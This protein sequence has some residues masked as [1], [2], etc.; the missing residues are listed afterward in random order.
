MGIK[1]KEIIGLI[2]LQ[3]FFLPLFAQ[4]CN[5][6]SISNAPKEMTT[7]RFE[8]SGRISLGHPYTPSY[9]SSFGQNFNPNL[10]AKLQFKL[11]S[12]VTVFSYNTKGISASV[13]CPGQ[14]IWQGAS[15]VSYAGI[16][17]SYS[18]NQLIRKCCKPY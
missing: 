5:H 10:A 12:L 11:D 15:G 18:A 4:D 7:G 13:F 16:N 9:G 1:R 3:L 6:K 8:P 2:F 17:S 14:G